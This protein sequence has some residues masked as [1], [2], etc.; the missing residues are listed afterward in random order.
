MTT[1]NCIFVSFSLLWDSFQCWFFF[2]FSKGTAKQAKTSQI[3]RVRDAYAIFSCL[4]SP[5]PFCSHFAFLII[6]PHAS[7]L[8][9]VSSVI[10]V[11]FKP[12]PS[13]HYIFHVNSSLL[14]GSLHFSELLGFPKSR[15]LWFFMRLFCET[16]RISVF[17]KGSCLRKAVQLRW[18][19]FRNGQVCQNTDW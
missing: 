12:S 9:L 10:V 13:S 17:H 4:S 5:L 19:S 15:E 7:K 1:D 18:G 3:P 6:L 8:S 2:F 14:P 11:M 16:G